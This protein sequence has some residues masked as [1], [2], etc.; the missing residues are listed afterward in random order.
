MRVEA[1]ITS[2][3]WIPSEALS[4]PTRIPVDMGIGRY[5]DPPPDTLDDLT[6]LHEEGRF[7]FANE[8]A[9]WAEVVDGH[10]VDGGYSGRGY[11]CPTEVSLGMGQIAIAAVSLPDLQLEPVI[12][13]RGMTFTQTTGG[14][15]GAPLP[16]RISR[17]PFFRLT[18]RRC[19]RHWS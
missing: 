13:E 18:A 17:P 9:A 14:R 16:R 7:R 11:I 8:L 6:G 1:S 19:G 2:V 10:I 4:G 5:D 12:D 15:T 3:S